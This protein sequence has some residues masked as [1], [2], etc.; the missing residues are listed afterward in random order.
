LVALR[1]SS[2]SNFVASEKLP[3]ELARY[4]RDCWVRSACGTAVATFHAESAVRRMVW[5]PDTESI[6][7]TVTLACANKAYIQWVVS[8]TPRLNP[9]PANKYYY[10]LAAYYLDQPA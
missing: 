6:S 8:I 9:K 3:E 10:A 7:S 4:I 1:L 2:C 5:N